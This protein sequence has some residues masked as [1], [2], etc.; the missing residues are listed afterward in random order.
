[1]PEQQGQR[2]V[3]VIPRQVA[4]WLTLAELIMAASPN[5]RAR[6]L[7]RASSRELER[8][9]PG[10]TGRGFHQ[11]VSHFKPDTIIHL[12]TKPIKLRRLA[13]PSRCDHYHLRFKVDILN[14]P[15]PSAEDDAL[16]L[17]QGLLTGSEPS[18][19]PSRSKRNSSSLVKAV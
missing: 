2:I 10:R 19:L 3:G 7:L 5:P 14:L 17:G 18:G 6:K 8:V 12:G 15:T 1:M 9:C 11:H 13:A 4:T 16:S